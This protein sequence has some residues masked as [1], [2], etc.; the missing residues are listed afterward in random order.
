MQLIDE[1]LRGHG[2]H[3][4]IESQR[5]QAIDPL[6]RQRDE[7][8]P[9]SAS[10][11]AGAPSGSMNSFELGSNTSTVAAERNSAARALDARRSSAGGPDAR[12]RNC[13]R[14]AR[15]LERRCEMLCRPRTSSMAKGCDYTQVSGNQCP[16]IA[17]G[18][19]AWLLIDKRRANRQ[20]TRLFWGPIRTPMSL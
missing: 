3:A 14:S 9:A 15:S 16:T 1:A 13:P 19:A 2:A 6:R 8:S 18:S 11:A 20:D 5:H 10:G 7:I 12:R 4:L 17:S